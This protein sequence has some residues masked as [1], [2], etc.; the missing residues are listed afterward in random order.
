MC[1]A[2]EVTRALRG[3]WNGGYG[4][5]RCPAHDDRQPSLSVAMGRE[6]RLLLKCFA[7]CSYEAVRAAVDAICPSAGAAS[8]AP[9]RES[10]VDQRASDGRRRNS[11][12]ALTLWHESKAIGGTLGEKYLRSRAV[13][14]PMPPSLRFHPRAY[15]PAGGTAPAIVA[16]IVRFGMGQPV[17]V[18][19]T[20]LR[21]PGAK[22]DLIPAKAMLGPVKGAA[23]HLAQGGGPLIIAEGVETS[24]S[25]AR[26]MANHDPSVWAALSAGGVAALQ[27]PA[28]RGDLI[29][30]PDPD[31]VGLN[32]ANQL[33]ARASSAGWRVRILPPPGEGGDWNDE[34]MRRAKK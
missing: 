12:R 26:L 34:L 17:A 25:L 27:L 32:A 31:R 15:H 8:P 30:A 13:H 28:T 33:A 1:R 18:H 7:G 24:L 9:H 5:C 19:R 6:G 23:A 3:R 11:E 16:A 29:V 21:E 22:T 14:G 4:S 20:Y 2:R 10:R